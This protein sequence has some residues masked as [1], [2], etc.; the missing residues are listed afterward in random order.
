MAAGRGV[1]RTLQLRRGCEVGEGWEVP[2]ERV[3]RPDH[4]STR[5]LEH[6]SRLVNV[7]LL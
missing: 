1:W 2:H 3:G 7:A 5:A 6:C 4:T